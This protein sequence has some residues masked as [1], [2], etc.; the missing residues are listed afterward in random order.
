[1]DIKAEAEAKT[2]AAVGV[3]LAALGGGAY[4]DVDAAT[5]AMLSHIGVFGIIFR[6]AVYGICGFETVVVVAYVVI[7]TAAAGV[8]VA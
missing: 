1:M 2:N 5:V 3:K 4:G 8:A 7:A 6:F